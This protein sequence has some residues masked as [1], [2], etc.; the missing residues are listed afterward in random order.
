MRCLVAAGW[1][2]IIITATVVSLVAAV[3][4][5]AWRRYKVWKER[6]Y[7]QRFQ[8]VEEN[9]GEDALQVDLSRQI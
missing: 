7:A 4:V 5:L 2:A 1:A 3:A 9:K 8:D 6:R